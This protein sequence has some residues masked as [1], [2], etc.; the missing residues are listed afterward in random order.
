MLADVVH[1]GGVNPRHE[2]GDGFPDV[3]G[4]PIASSTNLELQASGCRGVR[5]LG[6]DLLDGIV[7]LLSIVVVRISLMCGLVQGHMLA[8]EVGFPHTELTLVALP[9]LSV[10]H[11]DAVGV[12]TNPA[13][14]LSGV[15][16]VLVRWVPIGWGLIT[17]T[18]SPTLNLC[19]VELWAD[20]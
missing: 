12:L 6:Q 8:T 7:V 18:G 2:R 9:E 5:T 19:A 1:E 4:R 3:V 17:H 16:Q 14:H 10:T 20:F 11:L 15:N 13:D